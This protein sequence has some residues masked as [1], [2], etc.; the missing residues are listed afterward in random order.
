[1]ITITSEV[2]VP[3]TVY[4]GISACHCM[5]V[6]HANTTKLSNVTQPTQ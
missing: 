5:T 1:M 4:I 6:S 2:T 3:G